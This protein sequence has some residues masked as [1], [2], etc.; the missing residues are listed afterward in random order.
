MTT[1]RIV[2][3]KKTYEDDPSWRSIEYTIYKRFLLFFW[4]P[5]RSPRPDKRK[6]RWWNYFNDDY[7]YLP[8][9]S[10]LSYMEN[11]VEGFIEAEKT[12]TKTL[13]TKKTVKE[14]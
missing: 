4:V 13:I 10:V 7:W 3:Y 2:E 5:V 12:K 8:T 1:Y 9:S 14:Y 6:P 11:K